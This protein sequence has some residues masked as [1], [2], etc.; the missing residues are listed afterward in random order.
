MNT[1][2]SVI[3]QI[4]SGLV[5]SVIKSFQIYTLLPVPNSLLVSVSVGTWKATTKE[6]FSVTF[7]LNLISLAKLKTGNSIYAVSVTNLKAFN[8]EHV[9]HKDKINP[10]QRK[11]Q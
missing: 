6:A 2:A 4:N 10:M 1:L 9:A 3:L 11:L 5:N 8:L 7:S